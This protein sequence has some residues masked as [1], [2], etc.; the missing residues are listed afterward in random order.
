MPTNVF[1]KSQ[2]ANVAGQRDGFPSTNVPTAPTGTENSAASAKAAYAKLTQ[3]IADVTN[4]PLKNNT[5]L[6]QTGEVPRA[7]KS[8]WIFTTTEWRETKNEIEW[9]C[10][11]SDVS[12][13][14]SQRSIHVKNMLGTVLHVWPDSG[15]G[16]FY[17]EFVLSMKFQSGSIIPRKYSD[18]SWVI[19]RG[20]SNFYAFL[21][22]VDAPKLTAD[23]RI[24]LVEISY[25]SNI[26]GDVLLRGMF[27]SKG[28]SFT[29]DSSSPNEVRS[30]NADFIVYSSAPPLS[31][32]NL[33]ILLEQDPLTANYNSTRLN[34]PSLQGK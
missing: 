3:A 7:N 25:K 16:T 18:G 26:F 29:D 9:F 34:D 6:T 28:I 30:W 13:T 32:S 17:D 21:Q 19:A 15:R 10:N 12:W 8:S 20:L 33:S 24:N 2:S 4:P 22:L 11:P 1:N 27:D 14:M 5:N 31:N 23:G